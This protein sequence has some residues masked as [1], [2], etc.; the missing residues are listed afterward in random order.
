MNNLEFIK[1]ENM[2]TVGG[3]D[4]PK[5]L[6]I[7]D[8]NNSNVM[9][10]SYNTRIAILDFKNHALKVDKGLWDCSNTTSRYFRQALDRWGFRDVAKMNHNEKEQYF[11]ENKCFSELN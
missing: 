9:F 10:Q 8:Y 2:Q 6:L 1:V 3:N 5:Q 7:H 11:K 4:N